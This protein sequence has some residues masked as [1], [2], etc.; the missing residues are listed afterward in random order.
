M[1]AELQ[2]I[3]QLARTYF[4]HKSKAEEWLVRKQSIFGGNTPLQVVGMGKGPL[5]TN[6]LKEWIKIKQERQVEIDK[7]KQEKQNVT[8]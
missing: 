2:E 3:R 5:I 6:L 8:T 4:I 7:E 1:T